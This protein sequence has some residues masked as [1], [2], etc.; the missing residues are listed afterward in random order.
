MSYN[1]SASMIFRTLLFM[2]GIIKFDEFE[3]RMR[4]FE[5]AC[6]RTLTLDTYYPHVIPSLQEEVARRIDNLMS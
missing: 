3:K 6:D 2:C 1:M 4:I 5:T